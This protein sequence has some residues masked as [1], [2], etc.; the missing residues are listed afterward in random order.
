MYTKVLSLGLSRRHC[1]GGGGVWEVNSRGRMT[2]ILE[3]VREFHSTR[4]R[5]EERC[6][7]LAAEDCLIAVPVACLLYQLPAS[8]LCPSVTASGL[9]LFQHY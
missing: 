3:L 6:I 4:A 8:P 1:H 2:T 9:K 5:H 7:L